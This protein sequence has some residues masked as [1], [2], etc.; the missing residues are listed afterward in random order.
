MATS[1]TVQYSIYLRC[2]L[3]NTCTLTCVM[4]NTNAPFSRNPTV[5]RWKSSMAL[6]TSLE[7]KQKSFYLHWRCLCVP[8][9]ILPLAD[10]VQS[11]MWK[12]AELQQHCLLWHTWCICSTHGNHWC[13][14]L[15]FKS[16][17]VPWLLQNQRRPRRFK[18][19]VHWGQNHLPLGAWVRP[20]QP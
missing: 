9:W 4:K 1:T 10:S 2:V 17:D 8:V 11:S 13:D 5:W 7:W 6:Q 3:S 15:Q 16:A 18:A 12:M 14:S 20:T 19:A